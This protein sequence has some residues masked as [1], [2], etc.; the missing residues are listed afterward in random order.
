MTDNREVTM[1]RQ[2]WC[3]VVS[4]VFFLVDAILV[5]TGG[6]AS[7]VMPLAFLGAALNS[8]GHLP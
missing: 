6:G 8:A 2:S 7:W 1:S 5:F 4:T 3:F